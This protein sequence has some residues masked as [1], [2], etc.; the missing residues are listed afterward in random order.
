[1]FGHSGPIGQQI[2]KI[3][4]IQFVLLSFACIAVNWWEAGAVAVC[5]PVHDLLRVI[6][7]SG[8]VKGILVHLHTWQ[9]I[10]GELGSESVHMKA[11]FTQN[12]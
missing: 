10:S 2:S 11:C 8:L 6:E 4:I 3:E 1:M 5:I 9:G 7:K 12:N